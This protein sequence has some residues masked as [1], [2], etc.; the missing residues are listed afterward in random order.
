MPANTFE[1]IIEALVFGLFCIV[2]F[3]IAL[4]VVA[5]VIPFLLSNGI[6]AWAVVFAKLR[7]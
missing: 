5:I 1:R 6:D 7:R 4:L 3:G 2:F